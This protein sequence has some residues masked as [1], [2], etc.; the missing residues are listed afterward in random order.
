M[1]STQFVHWLKA[2]TEGKTKLNEFEVE[3]IQYV[4]HE[5]SEVDLFDNENIHPFPSEYQYDE[6]EIV[7]FSEWMKQKLN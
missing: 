1:T 2:Y 5:V 7:V 3:D 4:L 6:P